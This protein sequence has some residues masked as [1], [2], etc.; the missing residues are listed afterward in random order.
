[1]S[2]RSTGPGWRAGVLDLAASR[3]RRP[4]LP[5]T[6][7]QTWRGVNAGPGVLER[8]DISRA[9][10]DGRQLDRRRDDRAGL[11]RADGCSGPLARAG[12]LPHRDWETTVKEVRVSSSGTDTNRVRAEPFVICHSAEAAD[13]DRLIVHLAQLIDG[14]RPTG[15]P[16]A[17]TR[18]SGRSRASPGCAAPPA[19]AVNPAYMAEGLLAAGGGPVRRPGRVPSAVVMFSL[20]APCATGSATT[21]HRGPRRRPESLYRAKNRL[22]P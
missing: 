1:V 2:R 11:L 6:R 10:A 8:L 4:Q 13:R 5:R 22:R 9:T 17:A 19:A 7:E 20:R 21:S 16:D 3:P 18:S 12:A 15:P 14:S